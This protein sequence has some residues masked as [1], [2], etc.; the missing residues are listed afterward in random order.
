MRIVDAKDDDVQEVVKEVVQ[1]HLDGI[2]Q[3]LYYD[4]RMDASTDDMMVLVDTCIKKWM[5]EG[6]TY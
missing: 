5:K 1:K 2:C 4:Y 3:E 6:M